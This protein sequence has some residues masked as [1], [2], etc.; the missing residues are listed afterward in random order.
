[1]LETWNFIPCFAGFKQFHFG[2]RKTVKSIR[3]LEITS[4]TTK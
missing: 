3:V 2:K 1:M 4:K